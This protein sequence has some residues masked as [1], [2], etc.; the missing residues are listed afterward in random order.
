MMNNMLHRETFRTIKKTF[1]RFLSIA[2]MIALGCFA[3]VG[4]KVTGPDM[5]S[6]AEK[7][8]DTYQLAD[9]S[10]VSTYGLDETDAKAI[11]ANE[12]IDTIEYGYFYDAIE[13]RMNESIRVFSMT[14]K[15][16][17]Y[18]L[19]AGKL[20]EE[21]G[22]IALDQSLKSAY[23]LGSKI[24]LVNQDGKAIHSM[25]DRS[26]FTV[27][28]YVES[29]EFVS[30]TNLGSSTVGTGSLDTYGV[31]TE[32]HFDS[33]VYTMAR[34]KVKGASNYAYYEDAYTRL[35]NKST[36]HITSSL[37]NQPERRLAAIK[38]DGQKD[39]DQAQEKVDDAK[40]E[41]ADKKQELSDA[42]R[43]LMNAEG[44]Y[45]DN[46]A[47]YHQKV[48]SA[49]SKI[50][51]G[52]QELATAKQQLIDAERAI[53]NGAAK[54]VDAKAT[55]AEKKEQLADSKN[56]LDQA[57]DAIQANEEK[58]AVAS[59]E[60]EEAK[61]AL[62]EAKAEIVS[63]KKTVSAGKEEAAGA[64]AEINDAQAQL[65][66]K[67][68]EL[69]EAADQLSLLKAKKE[70]LLRDSASLEAE[71]EKLDETMAYLNEQITAL[72]TQIEK[73]QAAGE[74][75]TT[76]EVQLAG[77]K[78][79]L[80]EAEQG[81][82]TLAAKR[83][84]LATG[85]AELVASLMKLQEASEQGESELA[86]AQGELDA[87]QETVNSKIAELDN[88][89][90]KIAAGQ[91]KLKEKEEALSTQMA[92]YEEGLAELD[93]AKQQLAYGEEAYE[94]AAAKL[95]S[96]GVLLADK[97]QQ[98]EKSKAQLQSG[99]SEYEQKSDQLQQAIRQLDAQK[100]DGAKQLADAKEQIEA[101]F[102]TYEENET[103][104][105]E[106]KPEAEKEIANAEMKLADAK[107]EL[108]A[109]Q[110]PVYAVRDRTDNPSYKQ[111]WENSQ[112]VD[113]LAKVFPVI[114]F[115]I[116]AL[117]SLT[118][119]TRMV[120][121]ERQQ[122]GTLKALGYE[123]NTILS[124]YVVYGSLASIL[125]AT[126]GITLAH[127]I[128][129]TVI[130]NA[131]AAE[132]T[133]QTV[134]L[135]FFPVYSVIAL[136]VSIACTTVTVFLAARKEMGHTPMYL[137]TP[138]PP[139][140]GTRILLERITPLWS[141]LSFNNKVTARNLFR[142]K[143]RMLMTIF[144]VAGCTA[145]L[146]TGFGIKNS[147]SGLADK[148]FNTLI[149]YDILSVYDE[150]NKRADDYHKALADEEQIS[151]YGEIHYEAMTG[152]A[153][154]DNEQDIT[155]LVSDDHEM[156]E[157]YMT[158]QNRESGKKLSI[159]GDGII[160][161]E[162][163]AKVMEAEVGDKVTLRDEDDQE[164]SFKVSGIMEM[165]VGHYAFLTDEYYEKVLG[166]KAVNN[167]SLIKV[168]DDT[169]ENV[170]RV[171]ADVMNQEATTAVIKSNQ[172]SKTINEILGGLDNVVLVIIVCASLLAIVVIYNLTNINVSERIRELSTIKVLGFYPVEITLYVFKEIFALT[173]MGILAGYLGGY[174]LHAYINE[175]LP[176]DNA[177]FSPDLWISNFVISGLMTI[178]FSLIVMV[179]MHVKLKKVDMLEAL[180]SVE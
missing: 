12:N 173:I 22:E 56:R 119:M 152:M 144:G 140:I 54:L 26:A 38:E 120:S 74:D 21:A 115:G 43:E 2:A 39:I 29:S 179:I 23:D 129:P 148:Q 86:A 134:D 5:R 7:I 126:V 51:S 65:D 131:Y 57:S 150:D 130:F 37:E 178:G 16:S 17:K 108:N 110:L 137:M 136:F 52:E 139:K 76:L 4:L 30:K 175:T 63:K 138:K 33:D 8:Y 172:S 77:L 106:A 31:V 154:D 19:L 92:V 113:S 10:I 90:A 28:G 24:E 72:S 79:G 153:A 161:S 128:L 104:F 48:S 97:G 3:F 84:E 61:A 165:Y 107:D 45:N 105:L 75:T 82:Q 156:L 166:E 118:T 64:Q 164:Y 111:Y 127:Y 155:M 180:K 50:E 159:E 143:K 6:T 94:E 102:E 58:L 98:L 147:L 146:I 87:K 59:A 18:N 49:K 133:F 83:E 55:Y 167:A 145:L 15:L 34:I 95:A 151:S 177:M 112:R 85:T 1:G 78:A 171:A 125:G 91:A 103:K 163:L 36:A 46:Q 81:E 14:N 89:Q 42:K 124:K 25:L 68:V 121:E 168:K 149:R 174:L 13:K 132:Y 101:G 11:E 40:R 35:I 114:L 99:Q 47:L 73:L 169:A 122:I 157:D 66:S 69:D 70:E 27:V 80:V 53:E 141:R 20:P 170:D 62:Q 176:P 32:D 116:A 100:A 71:Q 109:L 123:N 117:V 160:L 162:K 88:A 9:V 44:E 67:S 60:I 158:L 41:L 142:Y 93:K 96:T 135:N